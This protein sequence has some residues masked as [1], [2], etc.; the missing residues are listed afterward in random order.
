MTR[1]RTVRSKKRLI[2]KALKEKK[3][4]DIVPEVRK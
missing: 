3:G 1:K 4:K 2:S